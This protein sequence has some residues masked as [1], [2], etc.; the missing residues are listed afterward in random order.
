MATSENCG[1]PPSASATRNR[2]GRRPGQRDDARRDDGA[3]L[4]LLPEDQ[5]GERRDRQLGGVARKVG[6]GSLL[7]I[8]KASALGVLTLLLSA[9]VIGAM[10]MVLYRRERGAF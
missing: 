6:I 8:G 3:A 2:L 10:I 1:C 7:E 4:A 9:T 5:V